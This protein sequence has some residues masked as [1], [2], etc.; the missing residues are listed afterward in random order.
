M[1]ESDLGQALVML[2]GSTI[3][4][5]LGIFFWYIVGKNTFSWIVLFWIG[6]GTTMFVAALKA[7]E[8]A[9]GIQIGIFTFWNTIGVYWILIGL[10]IPKAPLRG[11]ILLVFI[12]IGIIVGKLFF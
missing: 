9:L 4:F 6:T 3:F 7:V 12:G 11:R 1:V 5:G 8:G 2:V 10:L